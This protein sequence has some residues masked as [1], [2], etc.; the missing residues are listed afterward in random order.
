MEYGNRGEGVNVS[1]RVAWS[2]QLTKKEAQKITMKAVFS[3]ADSWEPAVSS[4]KAK[5]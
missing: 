5:K 2:R 1:G 4:G 3:K